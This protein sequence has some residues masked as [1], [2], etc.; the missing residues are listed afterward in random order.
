M[1]TANELHACGDFTFDKTYLSEVQFIRDQI[2]EG[3][4]TFMSACVYARNQ[5]LQKKIIP[6]ILKVEC[7]NKLGQK[8]VREVDVTGNAIIE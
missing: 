5:N 2:N 6:E 8:Y 1:K 7:K 4:V 3:K